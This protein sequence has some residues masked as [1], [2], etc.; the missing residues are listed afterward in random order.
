MTGK[1]NGNR[2]SLTCAFPSTAATYTE[3][4]MQGKLKRRQIL[5]PGT[6]RLV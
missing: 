6:L 1:T 4:Y 5:W 3:L 2:Y